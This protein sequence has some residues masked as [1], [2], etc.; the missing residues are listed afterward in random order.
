MDSRN[1]LRL[2]LHTKRAAQPTRETANSAERP[3]TAPPIVNEAARL[4]S[5]SGGNSIDFCSACERWARP[6][7]ECSQAMP[8]CMVAN[9]ADAC[10]PTSTS[11]SALFWI[12]GEGSAASTALCR[13]AAKPASALFGVALV[14]GGFPTSASLFSWAAPAAGWL[15]W[16][17][18]LS[19]AFAGAAPG[20]GGVI[21]MLAHVFHTW[22][23]CSPSQRQERTY[24][25]GGRS[26]GTCRRS[27]T[28][29]VILPPLS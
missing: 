25:P 23:V 9:S 18:G 24:S 28:L 4:G 13:T 20:A 27:T 2:F 17:P 22:G 11:T 1:R 26:W 16:A 21:R 10:A 29:N 14:A 5:A 7:L 6:W 3:L 15:V 8:P 19:S 12:A